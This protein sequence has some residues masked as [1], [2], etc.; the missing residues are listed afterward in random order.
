MAPNR[1]AGSFCRCTA[2]GVLHTKM[3]TNHPALPL[4]I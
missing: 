2:G 4:A 1:A 3:H